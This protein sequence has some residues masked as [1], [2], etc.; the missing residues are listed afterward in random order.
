[1]S[2]DVSG[3][4]FTDPGGRVVGEAGVSVS[5]FFLSAICRLKTCSGVTL[6]PSCLGGKL[7]GE[8]Y[9]QKVHQL[10]L[11]HF[12]PGSCGESGTS[13]PMSPGL[14][15]H[16][17][18]HLYHMRGSLLLSFLFL[19]L[20]LGQS[21]LHV[22]FLAISALF[23]PQECLTC[24]QVTCFSDLRCCPAG[25]GHFACIA[26]LLFPVEHFIGNTDQLRSVH[27]KCNT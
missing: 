11:H 18:Y 17:R 19:C 12:I 1:M 4:L 6:T 25:K 15:L 20:G 13:S 26:L 22:V 16:H 2:T 21:L 7:Q 23:L 10:I 27:S 24:L 14:V 9:H 5:G 3:Y 8:V